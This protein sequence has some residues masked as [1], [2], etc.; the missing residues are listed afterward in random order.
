MKNLLLPLLFL[1][2]SPTVAMYV[3]TD[4]DMDFTLLSD[5]LTPGDFI[6]VTTKDGLAPGPGPKVLAGGATAF[7]VLLADQNHAELPIP[8]LPGAFT[9]QVPPN[10]FDVAL[11]YDLKW[12]NP[13]T[14]FNF[15]DDTHLLTWNV[16][17]WDSYDEDVTVLVTD[18]GS[19]SAIPVPAAVWLFASGLIGMVGLARRRA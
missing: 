10:I 15:G 2:A 17:D 1:F 18:A 7:P 5:P 6:A 11:F 9:A 3:P 19:L 12:Y 16:G 14:V 8:D 13:D 4:G